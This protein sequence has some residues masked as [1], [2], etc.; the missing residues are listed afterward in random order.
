MNII[1]SNFCDLW[2]QLSYRKKKEFAALIFLSVTTSFFEVVSIGAVFPFLGAISNPSMLLESPYLKDYFLM[3]E[4]KL[5]E[6][7]LLPAVL[8][9][10]T[11]ALMAGIIRSLLLWATTRFSLNA[12]SELSSDIYLRTIFQTYQVHVERNTSVIINGVIAQINT[13]IYEILMPLMTLIS[14]VIIALVIMITLIWFDPLVS[15]MIFLVFGALYGVLVL[16]TKRQIASNSLVIAQ[17]STMIVKSVQEGLGSIRDIII[18]GSQMVYWRI[19]QKSNIPLRRA[20]ANN[21]FIGNCPRYIIESFGMVLISALAFFLIKHS[22]QDHALTLPFLGAIALG[23]QR[24]LPLF[25]QSYLSW[26]TIRGAQDT[27]SKVLDLLKQDISSNTLREDIGEFES[28]IKFTNVSFRYSSNSPWVLR[29]INLTINKG[30][31]VGIIGKTGSGKSTLV[32]VLMGLLPPTHGRIEV[33]EKNLW[34][35]NINSWQ[36]QIAHVPQSIYLSDATIRENIAF[37]VQSELIDMARIRAA[38]KQAN[39]SELIES[40]ENEYE[41]I[42]G[43]RGIKISGGQKQRLAIARALYKKARIIVLDEAT[44]AL[45]F[46][47]ESNIMETINGLDRNL[48]IFIIAHR[49]S[50]LSKCNKIIELNNGQLSEVENLLPHRIS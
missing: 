46:E 5:P 18:D 49:Q 43:E 1:V 40:W 24:L 13:V 30:D 10:S 39:I 20:Q 22:N 11:S 32:D 2:K 21:A 47:T 31:R 12:G 14:S 26:N 25:Q 34:C 44:S 33:D 15:V 37:G 19:F 17:S 16:V 6:Q 28:D 36:K 9:F 35:K 42:V 29:D 23:A 8:F 27:L 7:L 3:M 50:T 48:T 45:D 4:I 41:T 38:A